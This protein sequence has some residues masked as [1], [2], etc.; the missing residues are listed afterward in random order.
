MSEIDKCRNDLLYFVKH[1]VYIEVPVNGV[2]RFEPTDDQIKL[3]H[4]F[5]NNSHSLGVGDRQSGKTTCGAI[6]LLWRAMFYPDEEVVFVGANNDSIK[7]F[8]RILH[9]VYI[10]CPEFIRSETRFLSSSYMR[11]ENGSII[12]A[13]YSGSSRG[14]R[15]S[16]VYCDEFLFFDQE[17]FCNTLPRL[18]S[19]FPRTILVSSKK[20]S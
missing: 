11:F 10:R 12:R 3:L 4:N 14:I 5:H 13:V 19:T 8:M 15:G 2:I 9:R 20:E 17:F 6:Y 7:A 18:I 16:V 1:H